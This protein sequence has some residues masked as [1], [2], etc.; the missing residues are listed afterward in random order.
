MNYN[1][2]GT[3]LEVT[4]ELRTYIEKRLAHSEKFING[5]TSA[6]VDVELEHAAAREGER[7]RAE[8]TLQCAHHVYRASEWGSTLHEAIDLAGG[9]LTKELRRNKRKR[10][11]ML[12]HSAVRVKEYLRG[13]RTKV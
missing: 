11:H 13:W 10:L 9:E 2:K 3:G 4:D 1:I 12:R 7:F 8:Y 6:H 5:D